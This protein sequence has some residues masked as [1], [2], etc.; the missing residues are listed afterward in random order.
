[1]LMSFYFLV[2]KSAM[3]MWIVDCVGCVIH[4]WIRFY[5]FVRI[6]SFQKKNPISSKVKH[7][8][9]TLEISMSIELSHYSKFFVFSLFVRWIFNWKFFGL[10]LFYFYWN[11][12][13]QH[14]VF[15]LRVE[16]LLFTIKIHFTLMS[17]HIKWS[18]LF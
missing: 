2:P 9:S 17:I 1:M 8:R 15:Q 6:G 18:L 14:F 4:F 5:T 3:N 12:L 10:S 16:N 13:V 7:I 11:D